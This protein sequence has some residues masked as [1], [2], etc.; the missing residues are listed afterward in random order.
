M[1]F[2]R[3]KAVTLHYWHHSKRSLPRIMDVFYWPTVDL[4]LWGFITLFLNKTRLAEPGAVSFLLGAIIFW[5][6]FRRSQQD[7]TISFLEDIWS[8]NVINLF[9]SPLKLSEYLAAGMIVAFIKSIFVVGFMSLLALVFYHFSIISFGFSLIPFIALL[10][11]FG[12]VV[13]I[14][15]SALIFRFG[16]D[17]QIIAFSLAALLQPV[18][19]VFYPLSVLPKFLQKIAWAL[20]TSHIF[21]GMREVLSGSGLPVK[22][23]ALAGGLTVFYF[24]LASAFYLWTFGRVR[25]LGLISKIE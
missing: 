22:R 25:K 4:V 19:A 10:L 2:H 7:I 9:V 24:L 12:W 1:K 16:T 3:V 8:R 11:L 5:M 18:S 13:G 23:L 17:S 14:F 21:E 20:P 6:I 15:A